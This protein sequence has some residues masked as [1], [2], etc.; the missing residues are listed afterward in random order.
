MIT[1]MDS[2]LLYLLGAFGLL[3]LL[4]L[5]IFGLLVYSGLFTEINVK[6][7]KPPFGSIEIAYKYA[8]G[9][10][11]GSAL[12]FTE[13]HALAPMLSNLGIYYDNPKTVYYE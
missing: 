5:T 6:T 2:G 8:T 3:I 9:P 11:N 10:Y 12:M 7:C 13:V 4:L 1:M